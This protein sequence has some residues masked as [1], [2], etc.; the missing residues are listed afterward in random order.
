MK[1]RP[2]ESYLVLDTMVIINE[3]T[4]LVKFS[5]EADHIHIPNRS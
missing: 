4:V 2:R 1:W 3:L 5:T